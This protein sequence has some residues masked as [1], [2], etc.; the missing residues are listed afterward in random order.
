MLK[1]TT[2]SG[3]VYLV[4]PEERTFERVGAGEVP[5]QWFRNNTTVR[6]T[7]VEDLEVGN[8]PTF[9]QLGSW[10]NPDLCMRPSPIETIEEV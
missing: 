9:W 8:Q 10:M 2:K 3:R 7:F 5:G 1:L 4:D 6:Y